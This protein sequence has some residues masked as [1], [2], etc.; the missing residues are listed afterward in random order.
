LSRSEIIQWIKE[1][2]EDVVMC[3]SAIP[4]LCAKIIKQHNKSLVTPGEAVGITAAE[5]VGA[6]ITSTALND[7][8]RSGSVRRS[9][10]VD[11]I[12][13]GKAVSAVITQTALN[14]FHRSGSVHRSGQPNLDNINHWHYI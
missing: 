4:D 8:H 14:D 5:A 9:G 11:G 3:P 6:V 10:A 1:A 2:L 12:T 7:F 13:A